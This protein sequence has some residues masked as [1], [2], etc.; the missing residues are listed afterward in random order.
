MIFDR[1]R[2][3]KRSR[4]RGEKSEEKFFEVSSVHFIAA[5]S[6]DQTYREV[7]WI[8]WREISQEAGINYSE[9]TERRRVQNKE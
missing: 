3:E 5:N 1:L 2:L 4:M 6:F 9:L 7:L 8:D